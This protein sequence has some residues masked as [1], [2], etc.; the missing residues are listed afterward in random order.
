MATLASD[1]CAAC[2]FAVS[3]S[4]FLASS[5]SP[6][7]LS[8]S[9]PWVALV[10][11]SICAIAEARCAATTFLSSIALSSLALASLSFAASSRSFSCARIC[12]FIAVLAAI[13]AWVSRIP[14]NR[15]SFIFEKMLAIGFQVFI[16]A[17]MMKRFS[18]RIAFLSRKLPKAENI[19]NAT[20]ANC[21]APSP[22]AWKRF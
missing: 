11:A 14:A 22:S 2:S 8:S 15:G 9:L 1:D 20:F 18:A 4:A 13:T 5:R 12:A 19:G 10:R 3:S 6:A 7:S 17:Y 16:T 21:L